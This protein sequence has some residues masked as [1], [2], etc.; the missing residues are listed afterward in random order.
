MQL[1][2]TTDYAIRIVLYLTL[3]EKIISSKELSKEMGIPQNY[4]LKIARKLSHA[5]LIKVHVGTQG[6]F[7]IQRKAS[8]ISLFMIIQIMENTTKWNRC[9]EEDSYCSRQGAASCPVRKVYC[10]LQSELEAKLSSITIQDLL[11]N[12]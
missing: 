3:K 10:T 2:V 6:G 11:K 7:S 4:V 8:E 12:T 1:N 5:N 9:L